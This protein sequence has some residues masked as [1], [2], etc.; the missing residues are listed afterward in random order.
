VKVSIEEGRTVARGVD[1]D[2]IV[3]GLS[4]EWRTVERGDGDVEFEKHGG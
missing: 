2:L 4:D 3:K 1:S